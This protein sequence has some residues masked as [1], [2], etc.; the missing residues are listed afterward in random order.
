MA[1]QASRR[2]AERVMIGSLQKFGQRHNI[3]S[4]SQEPATA[5]GREAH[6]AWQ[7]FSAF[8]AGPVSTVPSRGQL[9]TGPH[10]GV[11][12]NPVGDPPE[13]NPPAPR[14]PPPAITASSRTS[15]SSPR[16]AFDSG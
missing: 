8:V 9:G 11:V 2:I 14:L 15:T 1:T 13:E 10:D 5:C 12:P 3:G 16:P 6:A 7:L 4:W